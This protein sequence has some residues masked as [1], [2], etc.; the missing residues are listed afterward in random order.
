MKNYFLAIAAFLGASGVALG[1]FGAHFLKS[2]VQAGLMTPD[3]LSAFD[4]AT[5]YQLFHALALLFLFFIN[6]DKNLKWF[7][8]SAK[9]FI[10]G[11]LLFSGSL[12]LLTTR[13]LTGIEALSF[14]GP[15]TPIGGLFLMGGWI[16]IMIQAFRWSKTDT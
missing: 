2:K 11:I 12:Y 10:T 7:N 9:L 15:I 6:Q 3:Q 5:K 1:A 14:L 16:A 4:T 13:N 8:R